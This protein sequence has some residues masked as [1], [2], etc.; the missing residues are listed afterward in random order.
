MDYISQVFAWMPPSCRILV[1]AVIVFFLIW[2]FSS[3]IR[4]ILDII[5]FA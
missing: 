3:F 5:P 1:L 4:R 2:V